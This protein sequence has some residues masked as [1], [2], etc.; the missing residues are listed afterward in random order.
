MGM[1][2][3]QITSLS[4]VYSSVYSDADQRKHHNSASLALVWEIHR[5]PVNSPH[6]RPVTRTFFSTWWHHGLLPLKLHAF[7]IVLIQYAYGFAV[8]CFLVLIVVWGMCQTRLLTYWGRNKPAAISQTPFSNVFYSIEISIS[9]TISL[10]FDPKGPINNLPTLVLITAW[11]R[12]GDKSFSE[13]M[14]A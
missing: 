12:S 2:T 3:S 10:K 14:M 9:I 4:I 6:K 7:E 11:R 5:W 8:V 13:P 1:M